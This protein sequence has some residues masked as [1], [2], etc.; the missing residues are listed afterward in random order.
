[1]KGNPAL[2][3]K[4]QEI[5]VLAQNEQS[6]TAMKTY[7]FEKMRLGEKE[8]ST[9]EPRFLLLLLKRA[10]IRVEGETFGSKEKERRELFE[11]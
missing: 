2:R 4:L 3:G 6:S 8:L 5:T 9:F 11:G 1:M 7:A 10:M